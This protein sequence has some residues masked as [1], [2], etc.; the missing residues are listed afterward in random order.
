MKIP[1]HFFLFNMAPASASQT[2]TAQEN[3]QI[4]TQ[5]QSNGFKLDMSDKR[6]GWLTPTDPRLPMETLREIF[7]KQGKLHVQKPL[8]CAV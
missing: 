5:L 8:L 6:L 1:R 2:S 4:A 7:N 3:R